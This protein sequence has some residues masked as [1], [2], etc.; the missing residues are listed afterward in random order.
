[1]ER[2]RRGL[3]TPTVNPPIPPNPKAPRP[4]APPSSTLIYRN[5]GLEGALTNRQQLPHSRSSI[6]KTTEVVVSQSTRFRVSRGETYLSSRP[7]S[8]LRES[9]ELLYCRTLG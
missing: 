9:N 5:K 2:G 4:P 7:F 3:M 6:S 8:A 1:M